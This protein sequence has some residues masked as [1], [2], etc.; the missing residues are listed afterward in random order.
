MPAIGKSWIHF[1]SPHFVRWSGC[2][3]A[4]GRL[5]GTATTNSVGKDA[6]GTEGSTTLFVAGSF[7]GL[8]Y[9]N[10]L[11]H[12]GTKLRLRFRANP[13][14]GFC[15]VREGARCAGQKPRESATTQAACALAAKA[16][17]HS[18]F[19]W[20]PTSQS[21]PCAVV[22]GDKC[23]EDVHNNS[24]VLTSNCKIGLCNH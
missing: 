2:T 24:V 14:K 13:I 4:Q 10:T 19:V 23:T 7:G 22:P 8:P 16:E 15:V 6:G 5:T 18:L 3:G 11:A 9:K 21:A 17:G 12:R 20:D 1:R